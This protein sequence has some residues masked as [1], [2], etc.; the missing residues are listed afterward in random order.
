M[1]LS[2]LLG[3][4]QPDKKP[5]QFDDILWGTTTPV[6]LTLGMEITQIRARGSCSVAVNNPQVYA[7]M[8]G[9]GSRMAAQVKGIIVVKVTDALFEVSRGKSDLIDIISSSDDIAEM[10]KAIS[11]PALNGYGLTL[12]KF[13]IQA[14]ERA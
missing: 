8:L 3:R 5:Q 11:E 10:V 7:Q 1:S 2:K 4:K 9:D 14:I 12:K 6:I 13:D